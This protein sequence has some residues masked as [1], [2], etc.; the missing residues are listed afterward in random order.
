MSYW[1]FDTVLV[2]CVC[3]GMYFLSG[4]HIFIS[5]LD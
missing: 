2:W 1:S 3:V 4:L 5:L